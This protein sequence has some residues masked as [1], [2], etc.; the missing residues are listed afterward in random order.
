MDQLKNKLNREFITVL[1]KYFPQTK[2]LAHFLIDTLDIG[3]ESAYRRIRNEVFFSFEEIAVIALKL[4]LSIDKFVGTNTRKA[5]F[6]IP[7][8]KTEKPEEMYRE[9]LQNNIEATRKIHEAKNS[10][11]YIVL[12]RLPYALITLCPVI[13]KFHYYKWFLHIHNGKIRTPF[14]KFELPDSL[15]ECFTEYSQLSYNMSGKV[16]LII[17]PNCILY[18]LKEIEYFYKSGHLNSND[19]KIMKEELLKIVE[20][21]SNIARKGI[22]EIHKAEIKIYLSNVDIEPSYLYTEYDENK[23][24]FI[25]SPAGDI[26][27]STNPEFCL[28]QK[29]WIESLFR[30]TILITQCNDIQQLKF[31]ETQRKY[32]NDL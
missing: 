23:A 32:I 8:Y 29:N 22:S 4:D 9:I 10:T 31:F 7:L 14:C 25:W 16:F 26:V 3:R 11:Q 2:D 24:F 21:M 1:Q 12:N 19:L 28:R 5:Y 6:N 30:Y 13:S 27:T 17:D 20:V 18:T 15:L